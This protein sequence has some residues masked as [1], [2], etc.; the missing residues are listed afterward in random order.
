[1]VISAL[2]LDTVPKRARAALAP[3]LVEVDVVVIV[4]VIVVAHGSARPVLGCGRCLCLSMEAKHGSQTKDARHDLGTSGPSL[5]Q[6][7][8][9]SFR[10]CAA[11]GDEGPRIDCRRVLDGIIFRMRSGCQWAKIP[12]VFGAKSTLH[13]WFQRSKL[14]EATIDAIVGERP[15]PDEVEQHLCLDKGYESRAA[16]ATTERHG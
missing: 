12:A 8:A 6:N 13:R 14:L 9:A 7:R 15:D 1:M 5:P 16:R 2:N 10:R 11:E 4:I 3:A